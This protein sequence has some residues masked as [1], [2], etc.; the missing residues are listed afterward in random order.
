MLDALTRKTYLE[1]ADW[2][3]EDS[4]AHGHTTGLVGINGAQGSGK[5][6]LAHFLAGQ[7]AQSAG[8]RC[9]VL[10][11]DDL[12]LPRQQ[13]LQ[14]A[15]EVHPLL[16]TRG[17]P[18]T[19]DAQW[20]QQLMQQIR[21]LPASERMQ[22]PRFSKTDDDRLPQDRWAW[23][24]GPVDILFFE[25]W[26]VGT[27]AQ[28]QDALDRPVNALEA[29]EDA[30]GRWRHYVN[31]QLRGPY[32]DWFAQLDRLIYLQIP[33]FALVHEWRSQQEADNRRREGGARAMDARQLERFIQHYERL[34]RHAMD[35]LPGRAD[36]CLR[37]REDHCV[38]QLSLGQTGDR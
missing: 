12:Y 15:N 33:D 6:T 16:A 1:L 18:G 38:D 25:G 7:L 27:P 11:I 22:L 23:L 34:T 37:L 35:C 13:R 19:H 26:C 4:Q 14:L 3:A 9:A 17:V 2:L 8:L 5:S 24:N 31:Q 36:V 10:S 28:D 21:H 29:Q 20:G 30:N 32:A